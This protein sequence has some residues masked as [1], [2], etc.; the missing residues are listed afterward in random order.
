M[1]DTRVVQLCVAVLVRV[2]LCECMSTNEVKPAYTCE[3]TETT[4]ENTESPHL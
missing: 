2:C 4:I 3:H 1:R